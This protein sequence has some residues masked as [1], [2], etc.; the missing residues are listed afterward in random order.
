MTITRIISGGQC[1]AD[2]GGLDAAIALGI[3]HGGWCPKGRRAENGRIPKR[4]QLEETPSNHYPMRT[5]MNVQNSDGTVIFTDGPMTRGSALTLRETVTFDR[6]VKH[7][8]LE[9][10]LDRAAEALREWLGDC[11]QF[12]TPVRTLNVAGSRQS[13]SPGIQQRVRSVIVHAL[14][15]SSLA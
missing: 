4:Y 9:I 10:G 7:I 13:K 15:S 12:G 6:A 1:G 8:N 14:S 3:E 11:E 2:Q 5:R